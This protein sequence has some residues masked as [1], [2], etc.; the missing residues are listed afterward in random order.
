VSTE[1]TITGTGVPHVAP[2]RA[3]PG[4]LVRH[5]GT[6]LQFD[7]GRATALRIHEAGARVEGLT[8]LFV[9]H[10]HSDHLTGL[11]DVVFTRWLHT[12]GRHVPLTIV[13]PTGPST[14]FVERMLDPWQADIR[15][16]MEHA[17]RDDGPDPVIVGFDATSEPREVW[18]NES[19]RVSAVAVH[20]EPVSPSVAYR[21]DTPDGTA[22]I[23]GDT[24]VCEE[25]GRLAQGADVL[26]H[27]AF[28]NRFLEPAR[29]QMPQLAAISHY[30][31]DTE[32]IGPM[33]AAAGVK[34]L[35]LT[36]LI[37]APGNDAQRRAFAD[38][39]EAGG[40]KGEI[41]VADDL[42]TVRF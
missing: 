9:T 12:Q 27:E 24:I 33:A 17:G 16:R 36:H 42:A 3:G 38:E 40:F 1:V 19:V 11:V 26:V 39:I 30:H 15:I 5:E 41:I 32:Q 18:S 23:S 35:V 20:H 28:R 37:P 31:A 22:V 8:A 10:H 21:I 14:R 6:A 13:A 2:G 29:K 34:T 25:V 4:V 7:A